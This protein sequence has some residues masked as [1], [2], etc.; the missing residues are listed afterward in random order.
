MD[1]EELLDSVQIDREV[2]NN[3]DELSSDTFLLTE[4][5]DTKKLI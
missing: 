2:G 5:S 3:F 1:F 4:E